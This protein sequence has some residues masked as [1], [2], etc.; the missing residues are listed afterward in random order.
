MYST[1]PPNN[2]ADLMS[3]AKQNANEAK[4]KANQ[5]LYD[6]NQPRRHDPK[7][8]RLKEGVA[9]FL[10][11]R[12][13]EDKRKKDEERKKKEKLL[14]LRNQDRKAANR[15]RKMLSMTKSA[16]KSCVDDARDCLNES[17]SAQGEIQPDEDD[18]GYTSNYADMMHKKMM[19]KYK[20]I[21]VKPAF[22]QQRGLPIPKAQSLAKNVGASNGSGWRKPHGEDQG[23]YSPEQDYEEPA[24]APAPAPSKPAKPSK[25]SNKPPPPDYQQLLLLAQQKARE[26]AL[27]TKVVV[28]KNAERD[29]FEFGR[30]MTAKEKAAFLAEKDLKDRVARRQDFKS[31]DKNNN[32]AND[33]KNAKDQGFK[34]PKARSKDEDTTPAKKPRI[35]EPEESKLLHRELSKPRQSEPT[36]S[37]SSPSSS[38][39]MRKPVEKPYKQ[40]D[41]AKPRER[42]SYK[43]SGGQS[44][45]EMRP[46]SHSDKQMGERSR[47]PPSMDRD[48][49]NVDQNRKPASPKD[50]RPKQGSSRESHQKSGLS[51]SRENSRMGM[52][53]MKPNSQRDQDSRPMKKDVPPARRD[54]VQYRKE[55][56]DRPAPRR[57]DSSQRKD[58]APPRRDESQYRRDESQNRRDESQ[59]RRDESQNRRDES[60]YRRDESQYRRDESQNRKEMSAPRREDAPYRKDV[61][62]PRRDGPP[63]ARSESQPQRRDVPAQRREMQP[64]RKDNMPPPRRE[65]PPA[66]RR[67]MSPPRYGPASGRRDGPPPRR[68]GPPPGRRDMKSSDRM[69]HEEPRMKPRPVKGRAVIDSDEEYDSEMDDFIDDSELDPGN[70]SAIIGQMFN[71][72][73]RK[74]AYEESD[75]EC[76]ESSVAQQMREE[77][78]SLRIGIQEDLEDIRR[79]EEEKR[80]SKIKLKKRVR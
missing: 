57:D 79:E 3:M 22:P 54:D 31:Y 55:R 19:E 76:M 41:T 64:Q 17:V 45:Q 74:Y 32:G 21:P 68:D 49:G 7:Q 11:K 36:R 48:R 62:P 30:P 80:M 56:P 8:V 50:Y 69:R 37:S 52:S 40:S 14:Q 20:A 15:V 70:I 29:E 16:N 53:S 23:D 18:Y 12:E 66:A 35:S 25:V 34:I 44:R 26:P 24:P 10:A 39:P 61:A 72:D 2:F 1:P 6:A 33:P 63:P 27:P 43:P 5:S 38:T 42:D 28:D 60:Q 51:D 75:D 4:R 59:Y 78:R 9:K 13:E 47:Y 77:Q 58:S 73:R 65:V 46:Q 71:Y 67:E